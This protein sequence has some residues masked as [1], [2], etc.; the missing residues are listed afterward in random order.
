MKRYIT[1]LLI[2]LSVILSLLLLETPLVANMESSLYGMYMRWS[3]GNKSASED[4]VLITV[5]QATIKS[6]GSK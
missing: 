2:G 5:D 1:L 3:I 6:I 4:I